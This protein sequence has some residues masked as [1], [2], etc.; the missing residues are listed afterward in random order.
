MLIATAIVKLSALSVLLYAD[1]LRF[2][3]N[4]TIHRCN[5]EVCV[6]FFSLASMNISVPSGSVAATALSQ[7]DAC[8]VATSA[9]DTLLKAAAI[10]WVVSILGM[11]AFARGIWP[12]SG[13]EHR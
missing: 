13:I 5:H 10:S 7:T 2:V 3:V 6:A 4:D 9:A 11:L 12:R 8:S 1:D